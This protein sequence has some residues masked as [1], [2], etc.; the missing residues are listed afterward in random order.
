MERLKKEI[1][2]VD[3][4][5]ARQY[6]REFHRDFARFQEISSF[7]DL[8]L[9]CARANLIYIGDYHALPSAQAF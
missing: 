3:P 6:I 1:F 4:N 9:A 2:G 8:V 5:S 7:D